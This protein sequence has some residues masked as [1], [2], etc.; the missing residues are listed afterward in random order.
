MIAITG[1]NG[2]VGSALCRHLSQRG[3]A[4]RPLSRAAGYDL[5]ADVPSLAGVRA[6]VH[7]AHDFTSDAANRDGTLRLLDACARDGV[8]QFVFISSLAAHAGA[9]STYGRGKWDLETRLTRPVRFSGQE[10]PIVT[11]LKPGTIL[12][13][14]GLFARVRQLTRLPALPV[15]YGRA[16]LQTVLIDD[17]CDAV[18]AA[19]DRRLAGTLIVA[20]P[21]GLPVVDFYR[22]VAALDG[23][24]PWLVRLSGD[25]ALPF[26][27]LAERTGVKLPITVDNLLGLKHLVPFD[28]AASVATLG[29]APR[30]FAASMRALS[31]TSVPAS[32]GNG[33]A[34]DVHV[35]R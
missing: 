21:A 20:E 1:A 4:V 7:C 16:L 17:L 12:G 19:V 30:D 24:R 13:N 35:P 33:N 15:F 14:G 29:V 34:P 26:L 27:R 3:D 8:Q 6:V 5:T 22:A 9:R 11:I 31:T 10:A 2:F 25:A 32:A 28:T 18:A 23:R